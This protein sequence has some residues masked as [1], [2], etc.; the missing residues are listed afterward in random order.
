MRPSDADVDKAHRE[1]KAADHASWA[2]RKL[3]Y[4]R[5]EAAIKAAEQAAREAGEAE[6]F[7]DTAPRTQAYLEAEKALAAA[8][9]S[10]AAEN[11]VASARYSRAY[12]ALESTRKDVL[13][14]D[15]A[16][17]E[18]AL[19]GA[20]KAQIRPW[21][22]SAA[23]DS[24]MATQ[25]ESEVWNLDAEY[26]R[27]DATAT[28]AAL[29]AW[30]AARLSAIATAATAKV[31]SAS[32]KPSAAAVATATTQAEAATQRE[33][34]ALERVRFPRWNCDSCMSAIG[35]PSAGLEAA[36]DEVKRFAALSARVEQMID[37]SMGV[38]AP[39]KAVE[40]DAFT[41]HVRVGAKQL[42]VMLTT[43]E[44]EFPEQRATGVSGVKLSAEMRA[45]AAGSA[46][47]IAALTPAMQGVSKDGDSTWA[48]E[49]TPA[50]PGRQILHFT[51]ISSVEL[52]GR[53]IPRSTLKTHLIEIGVAPQPK[54]PKPAPFWTSVDW[55]FWIPLVFFPIVGA[56]WKVYVYM[57]A[58][59][60]RTV[61]RPFLQRTRE[62]R[63]PA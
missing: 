60:R 63:T 8:A 43:L 18:F 54:P 40:G 17:S 56:L 23:R 6:A 20:S 58:N 5:G 38:S 34:E 15:V 2:L 61:P 52:G 37:G 10:A 41:A 4:V 48:W 9:S 50:R 32:P 35:A 49:V 59:G 22:D 45:Q 30:Q 51:V 26:D 31:V 47:T 19:S 7:T 39:A 21:S 42:A 24:A 28:S 12:A 1:R 55:R 29:H 53:E 36:T 11:A 57:R 27:A 16:I 3:H 25:L 33:K 44:K 62:R 46:F 14:W 13:A